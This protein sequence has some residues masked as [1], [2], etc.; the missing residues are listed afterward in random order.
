[1]FRI[2]KTGNVVKLFF[3]T[4]YTEVYIYNA[5]IRELGHYDAF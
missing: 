3:K 4:G 2:G 1:M 5:Y